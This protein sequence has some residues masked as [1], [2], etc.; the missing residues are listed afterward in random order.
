MKK[1]LAI[2]LLV[3]ITLSAAAAAAAEG[4]GAEPV[5]VTFFKGE[6]GEQPAEDIG[7]AVS[8]LKGKLSA[9]SIP[10]N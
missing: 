3:S 7:M 10:L 5:T 9:L 2:L 4:E 6:P 8:F 1:F